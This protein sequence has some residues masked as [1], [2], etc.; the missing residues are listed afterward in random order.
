MLRDLSHSMTLT[1]GL[2]LFLGCSAS[3]AAET[4]VLE[5]VKYRLKNGQLESFPKHR[6]A[7][8]RQISS[9]SGFIRAWSFQSVEDPSVIFDYVLW[10]SLAEAKSA[11]ALVVEAPQASGMMTAIDRVYFASHLIPVAGNPPLSPADSGGDRRV[12]LTT[13]SIPRTESPLRCKATPTSRLYVSVEEGFS[14]AEST[15]Y[16]YIHELGAGKALVRE[17]CGL[18]IA[19]RSTQTYRHYGE[20]VGKGD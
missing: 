17:A 18:T 15:D 10:D 5:A 3:P 20:V 14:D 11:A 12:S 19:G 16:L 13:V 1:L 6:A 4:V 2:L 7:A 8:F 9:Y